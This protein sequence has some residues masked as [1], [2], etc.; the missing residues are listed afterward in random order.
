MFTRGAGTPAPAQPAGNLPPEPVP[1]TGLSQPHSSPPGRPQSQLSAAQQWQAREQAQGALQPAAHSLS[2]GPGALAGRQPA[3][4]KLCPQLQ[5]QRGRPKGNS[6]GALNPKGSAGPARQPGAGRAAGAP[7]QSRQHS[8]V[9]LSQGAKA[10]PNSSFLV[11]S[12]CSIRVKMG[13]TC[14]HIPCQAFALGA[15][16]RLSAWIRCCW[17]GRGEPQWCWPGLKM[18][19]VAG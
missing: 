18:W 2:A 1:A 17:S 15:C 9:R 4:R 5:R 3:G 12:T 14:A 11:S 7:L 19:G 8:L 6:K 13:C 10:T 16:R